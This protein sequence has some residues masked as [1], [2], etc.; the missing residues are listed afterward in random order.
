MNAFLIFL[1]ILGSVTISTAA[2]VISVDSNGGGNYI[3]IQ[4]AVNNAQEG[5]TILVNP[6]I[7]KEN[8]KVEKKVSI[9]ANSSSEAPGKRIYVLGTVLDEEVFYVNSSNVTIDGFFIS[10][11]SS[12]GDKYEVGIYLEGVENCSLS[13]NALI[14]NDVGISL[15]GAKENYLVNNLV[16]L[17]YQG[18][19]LENSE[20]NTLLGNL[21]LT[22][23][24]GILLYNSA[25][26][27]LMNNTADSN[28]K[29]VSLEASDMNALTSNT[30][31]KNEYGIFTLKS[32]SNVLFNNSLYLNGVGA[33]FNDSSDNTVYMNDFVNYI[34]A[35]DEGTN[36]WN[37]SST[38]NYWDKY[39]GDDANG[40]RI[41]D[42]PY[43]INETTGSKDYMPL[44]NETSSYEVSEN[45]SEVDGNETFVT[46]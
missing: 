8:V 40:D 17:G 6:G 36:F 23:D 1:F 16:S 33:Y 43:V 19:A 13:N 9:L 4:E 32:K 18:I 12:G 3:S 41:G 28:T 10:G 46:N 45:E 35:E 20:D 37:T 25:N 30:I 2:A 38:G 21:M 11:V 26:N 27:T 39:S 24:M 31:S 5:D 42:T 15:T 44:M 34:N 14:M 7:Y 29:G 22:N